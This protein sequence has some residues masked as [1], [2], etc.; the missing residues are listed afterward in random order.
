MSYTETSNLANFRMH[1]GYLLI[2]GEDNQFYSYGCRSMD[3]V[4]QKLTDR[5]HEEV[6]FQHQISEDL[7]EDFYVANPENFTA[8]CD[9]L[10]AMD[11]ITDE[12][13][14]NEAFAQIFTDDRNYIV[15]DQQ[16]RIVMGYSHYN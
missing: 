9:D 7:G 11:I 10:D 4:Y 13:L 5:I 6:D 15:L 3:E 8:L 2:F 16:C 14:I 12:D 1:S